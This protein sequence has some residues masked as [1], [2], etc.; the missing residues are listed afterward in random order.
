L[1]FATACAQEILMPDAL[2]KFCVVIPCYNEEESIPNLVEK[3]VPVLEQATAGSWSIVFVDDGSRDSTAKLIWDLHAKDPRFHG[4]RLSRNFGHQPAVWTGI[5]H[6]QGECIGV[7][8][9]DLQDPPEVLVQ[10]YEKVAKEG[11]DVCSGVRAKRENTPA[12]LRAA[13]AIFYRIMGSMAEHDYTLDSGDFCVF[14]KRAHEVLKRLGEATPVH[15]GL[16]SWIGFKQTTVKYMRPP[17][18]HGQSKY[19]LARLS[20]LA[21]NNMTSFSTAPLRLATWVGIW[22]AVITLLFALVFTLNRFVPAFRPF[23]YDINAHAGTATI[24]LYISFIASALF[25]CLGIIGEYLAVIIKEVK[26]RPV[27]VVAETTED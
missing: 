24:V 10:L 19:N 4:V 22:M 16:R 23:G 2:P 3:L 18:L 17:R 14:N 15:R 5:Q 20:V 1:L 9:C 7:I 27:T 25:F 26:K 21:I 13:Y 11:C 12:W 8:D 6:A